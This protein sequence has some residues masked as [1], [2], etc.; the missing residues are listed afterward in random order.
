MALDQRMAESQSAQSEPQDT[1]KFVPKL[2]WE[3][4]KYGEQQA[5]VQK[6]VRF[7]AHSRLQ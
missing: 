4:S 6:L 1:S 3:Y 5:I 2:G 7:S